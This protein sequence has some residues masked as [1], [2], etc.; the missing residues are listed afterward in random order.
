V[1]E[2]YRA[3]ALSHDVASQERAIAHALRI[4][5]E[6]A[7]LLPLTRI[8]QRVYVGARVMGFVPSPLEGVDFRAVGLKGEP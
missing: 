7:P 8:R 6:D 4:V 5:A 3:C 2:D 1:D